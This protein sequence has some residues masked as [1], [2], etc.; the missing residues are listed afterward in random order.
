[1]YAAHLSSAY[2]TLC[3]W[4]LACR[5]RRRRGEKSL[6]QPFHELPATEIDFLEDID[7]FICSLRVL[8]V[9]VGTAVLELN[10]IFCTVLQYSYTLWNNLAASNLRYKEFVHDRRLA[11]SCARYGGRHRPLFGFDIFP[12]NHFVFYSQAGDFNYCSFKRIT[13]AA[14]ATVRGPYVRLPLDLSVRLV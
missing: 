12:S 5:L 9:K 7:V 10:I 4:P 2:R 3:W 1:M 8:S 6:S 13:S 11:N 14:S